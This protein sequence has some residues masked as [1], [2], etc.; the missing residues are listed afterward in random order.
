MLNDNMSKHAVVLCFGF[1]LGALAPMVPGCVEPNPDHCYNAGGDEHCKGKYGGTKPYCSDN[2]CVEV[3]TEDGCM[4]M[5]PAG[6]WYCDGRDADE[7]S[8][9]VGGGDGDGD[10]DAGGDGNG[11]GGGQENGDG[12]GDGETEPACMES[13]DCAAETPLCDAGDCV[14]CGKATQ[15]DCAT[16]YSNTPV[17]DESGRCVQCTD[18]D[19][20][21][22]PPD[23]PICEANVCVPC[24]EH[25]HCPGSA[26]NMATG[27]CMP[28]DNVWWVNNSAG[29]GGD[30]SQMSP[31]DEFEYA[32]DAIEE[33]GDVG[34]IFV[35]DGGSE[36]DEVIQINSPMTIAIIGD[37]AVTIATGGKG[38]VVNGGAVA[39]LSRIKVTGGTEGI[40]CDGGDLWLDKVR[41][42]HMTDASGAG[43]EVDSGSVTIRNSF[44]GG[45]ANKAPGVLVQ[46][47]TL[48]VVSS[49]LAT[50]FHAPA[51]KCKKDGTHVS[52]RNSL[53]VSM[54]EADEIEE[55]E[56]VTITT[57]ALEMQFD[58]NID[59]PQMTIMDDT[60]FDG[61]NDDDFHLSDT[62]P[63][64]I[65]TAAVWL[66]GDP[67][68]DIDGHPRPFGPDTSDFAGADVP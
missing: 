35:N 62:A 52:I 28:V 51:M 1:T 58:N 46:D 21:A 59:L 64:E 63:E 4:A 12:D 50:G 45:Y 16:E 66:A 68:T 7:C 55:C 39:M 29:P 30:G 42:L 67:S 60:W 54:S 24:R 10:G 26:C 41:V 38:V 32:L 57:S 5:L 23:M 2:S 34:T 17:C 19:V 65:S 20:S 3:P 8:D 22:C 43:V 31:F 48:T 11:D 6:C 44:V 49:T 61:F 47:G 53:I 18:A 15:T 14:A 9:M 27:A 40:S 36:Y 25:E 33:A 56:G 13:S 37:G